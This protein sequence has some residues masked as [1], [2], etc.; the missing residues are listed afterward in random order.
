MEDL[1]KFEKHIITENVVDHLMRKKT[2]SLILI[3]VNKLRSSLRL[4]RIYLLNFSIRLYSF[5]SVIVLICTIKTNKTVHGT[6][7]GCQGYIW[8]ERFSEL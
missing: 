8:S 3:E 6:G 5:S 2:N 7:E 1:L 4:S